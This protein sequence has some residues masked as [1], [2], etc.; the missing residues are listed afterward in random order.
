L[1]GIVLLVAGLNYQKN[2]DIM[3]KMLTK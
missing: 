3:K 1:L 2:L